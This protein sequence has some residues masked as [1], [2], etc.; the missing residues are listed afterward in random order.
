MAT[1]D[2]PTTLPSPLIGSL[3]EGRIP[4]Y[5]NDAAQVGAPRRRKRFTRTLKTFAFDLLLNDTTVAYLRTFIDTT[6]DGGVDEF[7]WT[8]PVT[9]V[10][11]EV[12]FAGDGLPEIKERTKAIYDVTIELEEI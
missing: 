12:R 1:I 2:W 6:T 7:N 8:H 9:A 4:A 3:R 5:V 10:E 11:Y